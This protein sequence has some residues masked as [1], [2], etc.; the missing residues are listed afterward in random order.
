M[1][2]TQVLPSPV[3][4]E[5]A[6]GLAEVITGATANKS[7]PQRWQPERLWADLAA[8]GWTSLAD[9]DA[10]GA[11]GDLAWYDLTVV[12]EAWGRALVGLPLVPTLVVRRWLADRPDA[13]AAIAIPVPEFDT[14]LLPYADTAALMLDGTTA[15]PLPD[16]S[17]TNTWCPSM[18]IATT[19]A[20]AALP[21]RVALDLAVLTLAEAVG[22]ADRA[23]QEAV[24]YAKI[25]KQ[26]DRPIGSFQAVKH[27]LADMHCNVELARSGVTWFATQREEMAG[28]VGTVLQMCSTVVEGAVQVFGGI[29]YTWECDLHFTLRHIAQAHRVIT[30]LVESAQL[31]D[32]PQIVVG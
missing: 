28:T 13:D 19:S 30:A 21:T 10:P 12:V 27:R 17:E 15:V 5:A 32:A 1:T 25:R 31:P 7:G 22:V 2:A 23:L 18:P 20:I 8:G 14:T 3:A 11:D 9:G 24:E 29:G 16:V 6:A 26:F 4:A